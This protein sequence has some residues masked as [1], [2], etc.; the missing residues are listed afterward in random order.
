MDVFYCGIFFT[1]WAECIPQN[2]NNKNS[3]NYVLKPHSAPPML[4]SH[5]VLICFVE[6][7]SRPE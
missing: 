6:H 7:V 2:H 4:I 3:K 5:P 1:S